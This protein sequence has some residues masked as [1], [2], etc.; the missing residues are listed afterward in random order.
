MVILKD[1]YNLQKILWTINSRVG[2][3]TVQQML[4]YLVFHLLYYCAFLQIP[5]ILRWFSQDP[6]YNNNYYYLLQTWVKGR[7]SLLAEQFWQTLLSSKEIA[8]L[9]WGTQFGEVHVSPQF[10]EK[11]W[12]LPLALAVPVWV[13]GM[14]SYISWLSKTDSLLIVTAMVN[15]RKLTTATLNGDYLWLTERFKTMIT[16]KS[17]VMVYVLIKR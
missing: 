2:T 10:V 7:D 17:A 16:F 8:T 9:R 3:D 6:G 12:I 1:I 14:Q 4:L 5:S 15:E 13:K 11:S